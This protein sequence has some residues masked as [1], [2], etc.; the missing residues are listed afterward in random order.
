MPDDPARVPEQWL[1]EDGDIIRMSSDSDVA[2][3]MALAR[4]LDGEEGDLSI[5]VCVRTTDLRLQIRE[6]ESGIVV[7]NL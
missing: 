5:Q 3:A 7:V 1:D 4:G 2:E 6:C